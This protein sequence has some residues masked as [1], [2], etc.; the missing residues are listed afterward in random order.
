MDKNVVT[1]KFAGVEYKIP[2]LPI[3]V[4][5]V[6]IPTVYKMRKAEDQG[7]DAMEGML[8][9]AT[10]GLAAVCG[11]TREQVEGMNTTIEE[12]REL[13]AVISVQCGMRLSEDAKAQLDAIKAEEDKDA[14]PL[15]EAAPTNPPTLSA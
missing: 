5:K 12:L 13:V 15:A 14:A 4:M 8:V 9:I 1:V 11:A 3:S 2:H 7:E 6:V 10:A